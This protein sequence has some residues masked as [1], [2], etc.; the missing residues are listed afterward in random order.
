MSF[1]GYLIKVNGT[2]VPSKYINTKT[3][4][5]TPDAQEVID[6]YVDGNEVKHETLSPHKRTE[7]KFDTN[8]MYLASKNAFMAIFSEKSNLAVEFYN[9]VTDS[10]QTGNFKRNDFEFSMSKIRGNEIIY[11]PISVLLEE[12]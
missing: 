11:Q 4:K 10:Y 9:H 2:I 1:L 8:G 3:Y 12:Y 6:K 5:A 7:I